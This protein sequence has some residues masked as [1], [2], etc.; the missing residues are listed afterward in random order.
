MKLTQQQLHSLTLLKRVF[1]KVMNVVASDFKRKTFRSSLR[2][3]DPELKCLLP[4]I[5]S[6][7]W[8]N[9]TAHDIALAFY[10]FWPN[11]MV[12]DIVIEREIR[13]HAAEYELLLHAPLPKRERARRDRPEGLVATRAAKVDTQIATWERKLKY[14]KTRLAKLRR[15][16]KYY[17]KKGQVTRVD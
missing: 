2:L 12:L 14:A 8:Q 4:A 7:V 15:K 3:L 13:K 11:D 1:D 9:P 5:A 17:S 10:A 16:Q 6:D